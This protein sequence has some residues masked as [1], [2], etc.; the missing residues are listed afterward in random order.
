MYKLLLAN[1][2]ETFGLQK[3][4][5]FKTHNVFSTKPL[6]EI[7][8][9]Q[10]QRELAGWLGYLCQTQVILKFRRVKKKTL[11]LSVF[12]KVSVLELKKYTVGIY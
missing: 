12:S 1:F 8:M 9:F 2:F 10:N 11:N 4:Q 7:G 3:L 5:Q 6:C